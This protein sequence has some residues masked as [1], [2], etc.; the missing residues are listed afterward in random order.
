ML[1]SLL[2]FMWAGLFELGGGYLI[3]QW[4]KDGKPFWWGIAGGIGLVVYGMLATL[5]P[6]NFGRVYAAYGGVFIVMAM[7]WGWK[8]DEVAPDRYDILGGCLAL[9]SVLITMYAPRA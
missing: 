6:A 3:W 2:N 1:K 8:V 4:L 9:L 7:L 5:Q